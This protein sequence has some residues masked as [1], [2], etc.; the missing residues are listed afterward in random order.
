MVKV[1]GKL[2]DDQTRCVH[3]NSPLDVMA[4]KFKCCQTFYSCYECHQEMTNHDPI[5]YDLNIKKE[6]ITP[7]IL[8]G[9]CQNEMTFEEYSK[10]I[11]CTNCLT[12]F[13]PGCKLHYDIYF[14]N[15]PSNLQ[16][17]EL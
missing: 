13:N 6:A 14:K 16:S 15:V 10:G 4:I 12:N 17:C 5:V 9:K 1:V 7:T 3:W 8:C 11:K 2:V